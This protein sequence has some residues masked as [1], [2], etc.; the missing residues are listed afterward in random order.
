MIETITFL[1]AMDLTKIKYMPDRYYIRLDGFDMENLNKFAQDA[2]FSLQQA[3]YIHEYY[4]YL[5]NITTF[6]GAREFNVAF[7]DKVRL[8]TRLTKKAGLDAFPI[9]TNTLECCKADID[10]WESIDELIELDD[11]DSDFVQKCYDSCNKRIDILRYHKRRIPMSIQ[12]GDATVR[13]VHLYYTFDVRGVK[14]AQSFSLSD[15]VIDEFLNASIDEF[16]FQHDLANNCDV[17]KNQPHFPYRTFDDLIR[18]FKVSDDLEAK[19]KIMI[20]YF[21]LHSFNPIDCL[22]NTLL[23]IKKKG[24][25]FFEQN[26]EQ[27]LI[28]LLKGNEL[29][30]YADLMKYEKS[31]VDECLQA[32]RKNLAD[33]MT[34]IYEKQYKSY[35]LL[36]KD[37]FYFIRPFLVSNI[38][39]EKGRQDFLNLFEDIRTALGEPLLVQDRQMYGAD[40]DSYKNHLA[41]QIASYE[42]MD[43]LVVNKIAKRIPKRKAKYSYPVE[44]DDCDKIGN[45]PEITPNNPLTETW[46][47]ALNDLGLYGLYIDYQKQ[48]Q[49]EECV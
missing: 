19:Y 7:Q 5:T 3:I 17:L 46:H 24:L 37:F 36:N 20:A 26:P 25:D 48:H 43:S 11:I 21:A 14:N 44:T 18:Y 47:V 41:F 33:T 29:S 27:F 10:Y 22:V 49:C 30:L 1:P 38:D 8:I 32:G 23:A 4:H 16:L 35:G 39:S 12:V 45:L 2:T 15:G 9:R 42:I 34:L 40:T 6:F 28:N 13:G 31:Y